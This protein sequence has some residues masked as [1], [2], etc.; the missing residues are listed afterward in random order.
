V[1]EQT[2]R[3]LR[4]V[5]LFLA[6]FS[7]Q[8][9]L[10]AGFIVLAAVLLVEPAPGLPLPR[11]WPI[12]FL[13]ASGACVLSIV[14]PYSA[15]VGAGVGSAIATL[16]AARGLLVAS[17]PAPTSVQWVGVVLWGLLV[18]VGL[19]WPRIAY[20]SGVK[21][22]LDVAAQGKPKEPAVRIGE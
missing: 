1:N 10:A 18:V 22:L 4:R 11:F 9:Y 12:A 14:K 13:L 15:R 2:R 16:A 7:L 20:D 3:R 6:A 17:S 21:H 5:R 8:L 19:R